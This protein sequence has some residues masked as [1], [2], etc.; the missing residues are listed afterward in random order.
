MTAPGRASVVPAMA[1]K[2]SQ[3]DSG[4]TFA[5][6]GEDDFRDFAR[7]HGTSPEIGRIGTY[8]EEAEDHGNEPHLFGLLGCGELCA[9]VCCTLGKHA[10]DH[11]DICKLDSVIVHDD[12]RKR[13]LASALVANAF[14]DLMNDQDLNITKIYSHAV[15][16]AT[17]KLLSQLAF[18]EPPPVGAP[19]SSLHL[20]DENRDS[21]MTNCLVSSQ[22]TVNRLKLQCQFCLGNHRRAIP[23]CNRGRT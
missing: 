2:A 20:D 12:L 14:L 19:I 22:S 10:T 11:S 1:N 3:E 9:V 15:H 16:P 18:S 13:G 5:R 7:H 4:L 8:F 23:W 21:F 17:V 6:I